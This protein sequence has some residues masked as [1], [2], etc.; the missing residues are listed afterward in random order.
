MGH[1]IGGMTPRTTRGNRSWSYALWFI[2]GLALV[3]R[4]VYL[5]QYQQSA[6]WDQLTV[7][8]WYH[9]NWANSLAEGNLFGDTT[10]FRAPFYI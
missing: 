5:L 6:L 3:I 9:H 7:D 10:Y 2:I 8:N 4:V 1:Y